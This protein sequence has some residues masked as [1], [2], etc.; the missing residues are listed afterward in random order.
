[1]ALNYG[2]P[3]M[4]GFWEFRASLCAAADSQGNA[5][6]PSAGLIG[7]AFSRPE[8]AWRRLQELRQLPTRGSNAGVLPN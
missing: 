2:I 6:P 1:M 7:G 5:A 8:Q 4:V 3:T